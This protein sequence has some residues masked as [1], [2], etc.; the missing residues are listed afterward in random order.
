[1]NSG[2]IPCG[3]GARDSLRIGAGLPLYGQEFNE[4]VNPFMTRYKWVVK[5]DSE[6]IG[7]PALEALK[8]Q[9]PKR[10]TV[11]WIA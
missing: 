10:V 1:M 8:A 5:F 6:F 9:Q 4:T 7:K 3:L 2:I 11:G